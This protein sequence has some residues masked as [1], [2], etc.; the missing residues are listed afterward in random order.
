M[1]SSNLP[2]SGRHTPPPASAA[3]SALA[4]SSPPYLIQY[5]RDRVQAFDDSIEQELFTSEEFLTCLDFDDSDAL[6]PSRIPCSLSGFFSVDGFLSL[7]NG[8]AGF[9][10]AK[11]ENHLLCIYLFLTT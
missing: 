11:R 6:L 3:K 8:I 9:I 1:S 2:E 4:K 10:K 5:K 7:A